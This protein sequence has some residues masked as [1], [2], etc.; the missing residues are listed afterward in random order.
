M[1]LIIVPLPQAVYP[2]LSYTIVSISAWLRLCDV[3]ESV[4]ATVLFRRFISPELPFLKPFSFC[5]KDTSSI[6][7]DPKLTYI[8]I[9][10]QFGSFA[11][12][13]KRDIRFASVQNHIYIAGTCAPG[14][15]VI[16]LACIWP[17]FMI[18]R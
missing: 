11:G 2:I 10:V 6:S 1:S 17:F 14:F 4:S 18:F 5:I 9:D 16:V 12:A 3:C 13:E 15:T 7:L 8:H